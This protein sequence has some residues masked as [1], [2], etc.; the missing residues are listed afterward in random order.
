MRNQPKRIEEQMYGLDE[1]AMERAE[2]GPA[3][4]EVLMSEEAVVRPLQK[5]LQDHRQEQLPNKKPYKSFCN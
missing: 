1:A 4:S 5:C 3:A 2:H